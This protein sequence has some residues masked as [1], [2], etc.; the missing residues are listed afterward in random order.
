MLVFREIVYS[1]QEAPRSTCEGQASSLMSEQLFSS[2]V[3]NGEVNPSIFRVLG[4]GWR[5]RMTLALFF[6]L[7]PGE[8]QR[9]PCPQAV[10]KAIGDPKVKNLHSQQLQRQ[11]G[12]KSE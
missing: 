12:M 10:S 7:Y 1:Y 5:K 4:L 11:I 6:H 8:L 2:C 9:L 3:N